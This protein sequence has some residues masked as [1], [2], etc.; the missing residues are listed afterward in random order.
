MKTLVAAIGF[1]AI[2][3]T[4]ASAQYRPYGD[5][6]YERTERRESHHEYCETRR[7]TVWNLEQM[8]RAGRANHDHR[9]ALIQLKTEYDRNCRGRY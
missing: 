4:A 1:L 9:M 2:G 7:R 8:N 3:A 6:G 5:R